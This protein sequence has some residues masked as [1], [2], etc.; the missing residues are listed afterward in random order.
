VNA[1]T[2]SQEIFD[3]QIALFLVFSPLLHT[4]IILNSER[5]IV[6]WK[7]FDNCMSPFSMFLSR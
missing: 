6:K 4:G 1:I 7:V 2:F 5:T 3:N